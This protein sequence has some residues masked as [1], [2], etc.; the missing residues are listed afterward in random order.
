MIF[1]LVEVPGLLYEFEP[2]RRELK[3]P[4]RETGRWIAVG[5]GV[6]A[7]GSISEKFLFT[8]KFQRCGNLFVLVDYS[9]L[10][11]NQKFNSI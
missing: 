4:R 7:A 10:K 2:G 6:S 9:P 1:Y 3:S 11:G 8:E 5:V